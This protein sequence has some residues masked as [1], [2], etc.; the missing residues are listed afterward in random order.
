MAT[1]TLTVQDSTRGGTTLSYTTN[2][3]SPA[4]NTSDTFTFANTGREAVIFQKTG[5]NPCTVTFDTPG[6]V[7]GL[8]VAQRT[9]TVAAGSGDAIATTTVVMFGPFPPNT[10]NAA[11]S[12]LLSGFTVSEVTGLNCRV[13]RI[14]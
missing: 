5:A 3:A 9:G 6:T 14:V 4:L 11:G 2:G 10:Y 8:A 13:V 12:S 7:D 1:V